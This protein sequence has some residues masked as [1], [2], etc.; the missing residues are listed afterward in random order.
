[1]P[2]NTENKVV[3]IPKKNHLYFLVKVIGIKNMSGGIGI[4]IDSK[5]EKNA[6]KFSEFLLPAIFIVFLIIL[7]I[8]FF[9]HFSNQLF[10]LCI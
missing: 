9:L 1:M 2:P 6:K 3:K 10:F 5:N 7:K 8:N 4:I